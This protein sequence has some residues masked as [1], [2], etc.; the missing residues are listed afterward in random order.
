MAA[1]KTVKQIADELGVSKQAVHQKRKSSTL[2]RALQPFTTTENG[3]VYIS[4]DGENILKQAF[5]AS[6]RKEVAGKQP[7]TDRQPNEDIV[8]VL[9]ATIDTLQGQLA[10]KDAQIAELTQANKA[11]AQSINADRHNELA[12]TLQQQL[13][14]P[15]PE[16]PPAEEQKKP[17]FLARLLGR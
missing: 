2:A 12:G 13:A 7:E 9:K 17:S 16:D 11:L 10:V 15:A 3:V 5:L 1:G 8:A 4:V 14:A 6:G